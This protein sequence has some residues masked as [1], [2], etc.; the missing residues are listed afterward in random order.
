VRYARNTK[1]PVSKSRMEIETI[2]ARYKCEQFG[3]AMAKDKAMVQFKMSSWLVRFVL[4]LP[5]SNEQDQRQ[6]WRALCL[7]IKSKLESVESKITSF[8]EEFLPHLVMPS[9]QT[10]AEFAVPQLKDMREKGKMPDMDLL[11]DHT[12][13]KRTG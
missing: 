7:C 3:S 5:N 1:V 10:F 4:P 11:E 9:G 13:G 6:R 12:G 2:L 8:E